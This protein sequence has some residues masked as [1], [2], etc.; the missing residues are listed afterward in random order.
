MCLKPL[1]TLMCKRAVAEIDFTDRLG[2]RWR[3]VES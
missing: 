3:M 2:F 1:A